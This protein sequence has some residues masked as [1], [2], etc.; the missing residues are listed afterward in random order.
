MRSWPQTLAVQ[1]VDDPTNSP[2]RIMYIRLVLTDSSKVT[3]IMT[4][5]AANP[6]LVT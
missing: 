6:E 4:N 3:K 1:F 5:A 2:K